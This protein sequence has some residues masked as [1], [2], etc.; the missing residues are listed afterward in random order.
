M[1]RPILPRGGSRTT[2]R[3]RLET[4]PDQVGGPLHAPEQYRT[5]AQRQ[6]ISP[7]FDET[8]LLDTDP[9]GKQAELHMM[10][11]RAPPELILAAIGDV[12]LGGLRS[13]LRAPAQKISGGKPSAVGPHDSYEHVA[14]GS[15]HDVSH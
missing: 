11:D 9:V 8:L 5:R 15:V 2:L 10:D 4:L 7:D 12:G 13:L 14:I 3:G 1:Y 6:S